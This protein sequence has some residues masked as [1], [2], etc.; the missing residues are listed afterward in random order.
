MIHF[1]FDILVGKMALG[2]S[3]VP[4]PKMPFVVGGSSSSMLAFAMPVGK[5]LPGSIG[6]ISHAECIKTTFAFDKGCADP[7]K[8]R[9]HFE[10]NLDELLGGSEWR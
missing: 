7:K 9:D 10:K 5:T 1:A 8:M 6:I 2:F 4:G 3:N